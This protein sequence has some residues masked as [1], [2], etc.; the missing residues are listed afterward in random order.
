MDTTSSEAP[1]PKP[2]YKWKDPEYIKLYNRQRYR[3]IYGIKRHVNIMDDGSLWSDS[4]PFGKYETM[5]EKLDD[6]KKYRKKPAVPRVTC[7]LCNKT[8]YATQDEKHQQ[9]KG[10]VKMAEAFRSFV[11]ASQK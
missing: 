5:R 10:H 7:S 11:A 1:P 3:E 9:S 2:Y 8:Y 4:H 6:L